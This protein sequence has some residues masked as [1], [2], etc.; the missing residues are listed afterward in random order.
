MKKW[1]LSLTL[2]LVIGVL[3]ACGGDS[4]ESAAGESKEKVIIGYFPNIDHAPAMVAREKGYYEEALG[5]NVE[6]EYKT[7][8]DGGNVYDGIKIRRN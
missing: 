4:E 6:I 7:F 8:P 1:L 5:E 2:L 3:A